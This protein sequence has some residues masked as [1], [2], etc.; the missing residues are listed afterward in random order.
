[1]SVSSSTTHISENLT[2]K[3]LANRWNEIPQG[4]AR[5]V[6]NRLQKRIAKAVKEGKHR[7]AKR[8]QYLLTHS[9]YAKVL[10]VQ[11]VT[12]NR[13]S[14]TPGVDGVRWTSSSSKMKAVLSLTDKG[15]NAQPLKRILIPKSNSDKKRPLSIPTMH[16]RAMQALYAL[17]LQPWAETTADKSSFGFRLHRCAQDAHEYAFVC[18]SKRGSAQWVVDGDIRGCFDNIS[19]EWLLRNIPMDKRILREFLS[20]GYVQFGQMFE[21]LSGVPQGGIISPILA[22]MTLDGLE[23]LL[24]SKFGGLQVYLVRYADDMIATAQS[25]EDA[26]KVQSIIAEF[27]MERGLE[28]SEEK[29]RIIHINEGFDFLG[30][31]FRKFNGK[32]LNKPSKK[33]IKAIIQKIR[34][35]VSLAKCWNQDKL[36]SRLNPVIRGWTMY[37]R[38]SVASEV[39]SLLDHIIWEMLYAWAKRRHSNKG[40]RWVVDRYWHPTGSRKWVFRTENQRLNFFTDTKIVRHQLLNMNK[41]PFIDAE[42]FEGRKTGDYSYQMSLFS[43][44][45]R[46]RIIGL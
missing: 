16:D 26:E 43:F 11:T 15:Y 42:Y 36:I 13:G 9:F 33:S 17:A 18:L 32:M 22:N 28:L 12:K 24:K 19:H 6:V 5:L 4:K 39:F 30:W 1:M 38:N 21:T 45:H 2:D 14:R 7:L 37:H 44:I 8:L 25:K 23:S 46:A 3:T 27:L 20:A 29:T 40:K 35:I 10:A 41:N 34:D 31:S